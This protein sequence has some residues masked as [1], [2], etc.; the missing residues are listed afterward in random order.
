MSFTNQG[1]RLPFRLDDCC[2]HY[3]LLDA[4][5]GFI[6]EIGR[7][8]EKAFS[9]VARVNAEYAEALIR[10]AGDPLVGHPA[11]D[12]S[13]ELRQVFEWVAQLAGDPTDYEAAELIAR[14]LIYELKP[15]EYRIAPEHEAAWEA[16]DDHTY[17]PKRAA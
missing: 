14:G 15:G 16:W 7:P 5:G 1:R 2:E 3:Q 6:A 13:P 9:Y 17:P 11:R 4:R 10:F 8:D 12:C